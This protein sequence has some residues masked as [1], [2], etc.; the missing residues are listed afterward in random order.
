MR[1]LV[2]PA[3]AVVMCLGFLGC[4][5]CDCPTEPAG[6]LL[7]PADLEV[8]RTSLTSLQL[9]W[10]DA[11]KYEEGYRIDRREGNGEW[12]EGHAI[13]PPNANEFVDVVQMSIRE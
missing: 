12:E 11:S 8:Q 7:A 6:D 13:L 5:D 2:L 3:C 9:T 4:S 1:Y 10:V